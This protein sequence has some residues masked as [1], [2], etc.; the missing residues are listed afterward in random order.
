L[1]PWRQIA[2]Q[3]CEEQDTDQLL[4][5]CREL[6]QALEEQGEAKREPVPDSQTNDGRRSA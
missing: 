3:A 5:L 2:Q 1:R 6:E 4:V